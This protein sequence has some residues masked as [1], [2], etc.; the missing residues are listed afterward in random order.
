M[1]RLNAAKKIVPEDFPE[2]SRPLIFK[3]ADV[4]NPFLYSVYAAISKQLTIDE[5]IKSQVYQIDLIAD[6]NT[7][8]LK[9]S[10]NQKPTVCLIGNATLD[11]KSFIS[12]PVSVS[13][14]VDSET[15]S[16]KFVGLAA[17]TK[18]KIT[19]IGIV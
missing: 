18:H 7:A 9:W 10:L 19:L 16:V 3:I 1:G 13:W 4:L 15:L 2:E 14:S 12:Q 17:G 11:D 5:N 8:K 6:Q